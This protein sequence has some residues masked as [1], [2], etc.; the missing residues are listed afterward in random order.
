M[1]DHCLKYKYVIT[2]AFIVWLSHPIGEILASKSKN[3]N[4]LY[5]GKYFTRQLILIKNKMAI[6]SFNNGLSWD[7]STRLLK[8]HGFFCG[9]CGH[10][11][12]LNLV[13]EE[14][15]SLTVIRTHL[16]ACSSFYLILRETLLEKNI[17]ILQ[18]MVLTIHRWILVFTQLL[19]TFFMKEFSVILVF[20]SQ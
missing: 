11:R 3:I 19:F 9:I 18:V 6:D 15:P 13:F 7:M 16:H 12:T 1:I 5:K 2:F 14:I 8:F 4:F 10:E 17:V 20:N